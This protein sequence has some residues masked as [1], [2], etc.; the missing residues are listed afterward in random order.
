[1][2][3]RH[4]R[5][6]LA[7]AETLHFARA[8]EGLGIAPPSLTVQIRDLESDLGT[9][10]FY[11]TKRVVRLSPAGEAFL[12][13]AQAVL[14]Q[15]ERAESVGRRAGR[16][17]I[18]RIEIGYVGSA[19][20]SGALQNHVAAFRRAQPAVEIVCTE[21]KMDALPDLLVE[22]QVD[23]AFVRLP[24]HL[25]AGLRARTVVR[26]RFRLAVATT[27]RWGDGWRGKSVDPAELAQ[28]LFVLPEQV[29]GTLEVG[30]RGG[31]TPR[32]G[33]HP[34]S[35]IS[36]ATYVAL[37][38][39]VAVVPSALPDSVHLP[40]VVFR[41]LA[42]KPIVSEIAVLHRHREQHP[43]VANLIKQIVPAA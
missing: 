5:A 10:L 18:G 36:V 40:G 43:V 8:A 23:L 2:D 17:E 34:G 27:S 41:E 24:M 19:T 26:D 13:E 14:A 3:L 15:V 30:R 32:L 42:G 16:G 33:P 6:F 12:P 22:G 38:T 37:G 9:T 11:R 21:H 35:L 7:V 39:G 20:Y 28:E 1:M 31:F 25:P 29:A 4:V